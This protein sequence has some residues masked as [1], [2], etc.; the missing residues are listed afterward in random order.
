MRCNI[1]LGP[2][3]S[4]SIDETKRFEI[5][6]CESCGREILKPINKNDKL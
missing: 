3:K 1:C 4:I 6:K 5:M 2:L